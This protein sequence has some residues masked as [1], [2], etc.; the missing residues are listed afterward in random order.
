LNSQGTTASGEGLCTEDA[1]GWLVNYC[2]KGARELTVLRLQ[3]ELGA[4]TDL[5][6]F[7]NYLGR[8][9][10]FVQGYIIT[11]QATNM[12]KRVAVQIHGG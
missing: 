10:R 9:G 4:V 12:Y 6:S 5:M 8:A 7:E 2:P 3:R 1:V 11:R